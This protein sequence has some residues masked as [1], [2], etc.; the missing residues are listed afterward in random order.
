MGLEELFRVHWGL[1]SGYLARRTGSRVEGEDLAQEVFYRAAK[2]WLGWKGTN[3]GAWLMA[4]A[5]TTLI[6]AQRKGR[7]TLTP[8]SEELTELSDS[9][10][11]L[12]VRDALARLPESQ[13]RLL[14]LVYVDG[15]S[16]AEIAAISDTTAAAVKTA[17]WRARE[18]F[19]EQWEVGR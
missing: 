8:L 3:A 18:A 1:V 16:H 4:I 10:D 15:F 14:T 5:R 19:K 11:D 17:V 2:G 9:S 7:F 12:D 13:R 6:D